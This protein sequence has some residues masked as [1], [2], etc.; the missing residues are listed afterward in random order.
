MSYRNLATGR[1]GLLALIIITGRLPVAMAPFAMVFL[2]R[3][4][5]G[6]YSLGAALAAAYVIGEA[7]GAPLLGLRA[8]PHRIRL[9]IGCGLA[10]GGILFGALALSRTSP[11]L[12]LLALAFGA[13]LAPAAS[14]GGMQVLEANIVAEEDVPSA[15]SAGA[16]LTTTIWAVAPVL[17]SVLA[18]EVSPAAPLLLGAICAELS[19]VLLIFLPVSIRSNQEA[20]VTG[21]SR[22]LL[23]A[24]PIILTSAAGM[25]LVASIELFLPALLESKR[26]GVGWT[27]VLL[28]AFSVV[29]AI[30][31]LVYG[32]KKWPGSHRAQSLVLLTAT[33]LCAGLIGW[34]PSLAWMF[35]SLVATGVLF[36]AAELSRSLSLRAK[37]PAEMHLAA[38]SVNY[39]AIGI[40]YGVS[41]VVAAAVLASGTPMT[42]LL[43]GAAVTVILLLVGYV[44]ERAM[45]VEKAAISA[46]GVPR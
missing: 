23:S 18:L 11:D 44:G 24:W 7:V 1:A 34:A 13:G 14:A 2:A 16:A 30:T 28:A 15:F 19:A 40:A 12:L 39:A 22:A 8:D 31:A 20:P 26:I 29:S 37:L 21:R 10:A 3:S 43:M 36:S 32:L 33:A 9:H 27:G 25:Y 42:G 38:F 6:G 4:T 45:S 35:T 46:T 17:V 41:A 5:S